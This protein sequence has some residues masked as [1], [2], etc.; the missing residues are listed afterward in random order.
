MNFSTRLGRARASFDLFDE[1]L[2]EQGRQI[3]R[4]QSELRRAQTQFD[5][6][7]EFQRELARVS[8][9][10]DAV[11]RLESQVEELCGIGSRK[12]PPIAA[13]Q[14]ECRRWSWLS[15]LWR[16]LRVPITLGGLTPGLRP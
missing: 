5:L 13:L 4:L 9:Q 8:G 6:M 14:R 15:S 12:Q 3:A 2:V 11:P 1:R 16:F 7:P 10:L